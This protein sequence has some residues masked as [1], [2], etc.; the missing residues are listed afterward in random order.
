MTEETEGRVFAAVFVSG[1]GAVPAAILFLVALRDPSP[2][3]VVWAA[4]FG[5]VVF[6][7]A[8]LAHACF[9]MR[10]EPL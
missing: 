1:V 5:L 10:Q 7:T 3:W 2:L 4:L 8:Y 9:K 6:L